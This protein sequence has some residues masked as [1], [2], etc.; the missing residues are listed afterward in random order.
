MKG[1]EGCCGN[2]RIWSREENKV[3]ERALAL[4][5]EDT[6][7]R[8]QN[9]ASMVGGRTVDEVRHHYDL[10]VEDLNCIESD[11]V[12]LPEYAQS[13]PVGQRRLQDSGD[14]RGWFD[15]GPRLFLRMSI[16]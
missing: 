7:D 1:G 10:L 11:K 5:D 2:G 16:K 14:L 4:Y 3:F 13:A 9:V 8:W 12:P 6:P 15:V